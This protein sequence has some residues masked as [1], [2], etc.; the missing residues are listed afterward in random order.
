MG[1]DHGPSEAVAAAAQLSIERPDFHLILVGD[2]VVI[3][4]LLDELEYEPGRL[5]LR[6]TD[7]WVSMDE[8][9][10]KAIAAKPNASVLVA[11]QLVSDGRADAV[12]TSGNTG[13]AIL[14]AARKMGRIPGVRRAALAAVTPTEKTHGPNDDPFALLLDVGA[15]LS[16]SGRDLVTFAIMGAAYAQAISGNPSPTVALLSNGTEA[17]KGPREVVEA[18]EM[19]ANLSEVNFAG[20]VEGLDIPRGSV[21]VVVTNGFLGNVVLKML[22]GIGEVISELANDAYA[23]KFL[24][25]F[26]LTMLSSGLRQI[27]QALDWEQY[28]GAPILGFVQPIIKAH[29]RSKARAIGN[30]CKVAVKA[31]RADMGREI[32]RA[33]SRVPA[34]EEEGAHAT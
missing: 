21:D 13:A 6:H 32:E 25:R 26:G 14:A 8:S 31:A 7:E 17:H 20:N 15:T 28:G 4:P 33:V 27:Q 2:A 19:L 3:G 34:P 24:W 5:S 30:A 16:A 29:G 9:P 11:C 1:G 10:A 18:H 22:E 12:V 23:R